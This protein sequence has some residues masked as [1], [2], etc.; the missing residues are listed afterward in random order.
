MKVLR[1]EV[2]LFPTVREG[3]TAPLAVIRLCA[4]T[5][6]TERRRGCVGSRCGR[7]GGLS[8]KSRDPTSRRARLSQSAQTGA[9]VPRRQA[10][11]LPSQRGQSSQPHPQEILVYGSDW[12][13]YKD[14]PDRR[15]APYN[16][17]CLQG[18]TDSLVVCFTPLNARPPA[19]EGHLLHRGTEGQR[20]R[21]E[22]GQQENF[23]SVGLRGVGPLWQH[24]CLVLC[25]VEW[26]SV[27]ELISGQHEKPG[28][29]YSA[30]KMS[31][32]GSERLMAADPF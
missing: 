6:G 15:G 30:N 1:P 11:V 18:K 26:V 13:A 24:T 20:T 2:T 31:D 32:D 29:V 3:S 22:D 14:V 23:V 12:R 27:K 10:S 21:V 19:A 16:G 25:V 17:E 4:P 9:S 28:S 5:S 7:S 8:Y